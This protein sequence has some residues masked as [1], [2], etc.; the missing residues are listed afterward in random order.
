MV[1]VLITFL[2]LIIDHMHSLTLATVI[3]DHKEFVEVDEIF[4]AK[5]P[6]ILKVDRTVTETMYSVLI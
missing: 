2:K 4:L 5:I 3:T 1:E 6:I